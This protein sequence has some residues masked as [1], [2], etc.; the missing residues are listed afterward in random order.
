MDGFGREEGGG[1][2]KRN[3]T[4]AEHSNGPGT[5]GPGGHLVGPTLLPTTRPPRPVTA[6]WGPEERPR[7]TL[8]ELIGGVR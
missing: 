4:S 2:R 5:P 6:H 3:K 1:G 7:C 8:A